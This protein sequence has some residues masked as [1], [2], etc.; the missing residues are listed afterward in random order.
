[1]LV[2]LRAS[3]AWSAVAHVVARAFEL[4]PDGT[5]VQ[6]PSVKGHMVNYLKAPG[7]V[8]GW[9]VE[10]IVPR[11]LKAGPRKSTV[12]QERALSETTSW[13]FGVGA[14]LGDGISTELVA[15]VHRTLVAEGDL[16][17]TIAKAG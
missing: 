9:K 6:L 3:G 15:F 5:T 1:L 14:G 4:A 10:A 8:L 16:E 7:S 17:K 2:K 11:R 13:G 12:V